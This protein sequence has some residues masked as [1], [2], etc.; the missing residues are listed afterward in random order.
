MPF[1]WGIRA[2]REMK[3][4]SP[5]KQKTLLRSHYKIK[6]LHL[7]MM[8]SISSSSVKT[9]SVAGI[10]HHQST[11]N[12]FWILRASSTIQTVKEKS[13]ILLTQGIKPLK[14]TTS[15]RHLVNKAIKRCFRMSNS[16]NSLPDSS[17]SMHSST[18][19]N[20]I[21]FVHRTKTTS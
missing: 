7:L 6:H 8:G 9:I 17:S 3:L 11:K 1:D 13:N 12:S 5:W 4:A 18:C 16:H 2:S 21:K 14:I 19:S 15:T 20:L 10:L